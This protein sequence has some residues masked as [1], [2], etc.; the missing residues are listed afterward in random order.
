MFSGGFFSFTFTLPFSIFIGLVLSFEFLV[1]LSP[2]FGE[3]L[4]VFF[5]AAF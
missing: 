3:F 4:G 1:A 2:F 5:E